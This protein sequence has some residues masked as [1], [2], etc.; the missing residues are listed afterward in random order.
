[1]TPG[2]ESQLEE[3]SEDMVASA[4]VEAGIEASEDMTASV[5]KAGAEVRNVTASTKKGVSFLEISLPTARLRSEVF[6][7]S[8]ADSWVVSVLSWK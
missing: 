8:S 5:L 2:R 7:D 1:M 6:A 3:V 4:G